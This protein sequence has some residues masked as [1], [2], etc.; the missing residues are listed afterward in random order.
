MNRELTPPR[1]AWFVVEVDVAHDRD[2]PLHAS[3]GGPF[4]SKDKA[5]QDRD[6]RQDAWD[7]AVEDHDGDSPYDFK[8]WDIVKKH[9][10][11]GRVDAL[12]R[13]DE[14]PH[15]IAQDAAD[16]AMEGVLNDDIQGP[17]D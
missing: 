16:A 12:G 14:E 2:N 9:L 11:D 17:R 5:E 10:H 6:E 4:P 1:E 3:I 15:Q 8:G 7:R 13:Q